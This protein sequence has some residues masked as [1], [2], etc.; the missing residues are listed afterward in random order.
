MDNDGIE[1]IE[2]PDRDGDGW[3]NIIEI[4]CNSNLDNIEL[5]PTLITIQYVMLQMKMNY[6][7]TG[8]S[9]EFDPMDKND[10]I[11]CQMLFKTLKL[12]LE[13]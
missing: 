3:M 12:F 1:D 8:K 7:M 2:D 10:A 5:K 13:D 11:I 6:Q 9:K 4:G